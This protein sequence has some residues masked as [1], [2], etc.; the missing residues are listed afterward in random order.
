M[1]TFFVLAI[2]V[3]FVS[4]TQVHAN[5]PPSKG[6]S[7]AQGNPSKGNPSAKGTGN[8]NQ[9]IDQ[10]LDA[11]IDLVTAG[12]TVAAARSLAVNAGY[13]GL[14]PLPPGIAKNLARGK[15]LP[16]G[17]ATRHL[18]HNL[19]RGLPYHEGYQWLAAGTNL[20]LVNTAS[21]V[22][23]DVLKDVLK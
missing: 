14:E 21:R 19:L 10:S 7:Q 11:A 22:I 2:T 12:I 16:P 6:N 8:A 18:P 4:V 5:P 20:L 9:L 13:V 23:A 15:P 17:I 3:A 1:K